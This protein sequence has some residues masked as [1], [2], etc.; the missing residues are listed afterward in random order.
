MIDIISAT[1]ISDNEEHITETFWHSEH[2]HTHQR[3]SLPRNM[4]QRKRENEWKMAN[5][6]N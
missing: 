2:A 3:S 4:K 5:K 6:Q 1:K